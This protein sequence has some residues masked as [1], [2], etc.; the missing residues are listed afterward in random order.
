MPF[1]SATHGLSVGTIAWKHNEKLP[2]LNMAL[3]R[4]GHMT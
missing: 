3:Q 2:A 1:F 4:A